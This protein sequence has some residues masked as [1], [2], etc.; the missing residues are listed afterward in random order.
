MKLQYTKYF[1]VGPLGSNLFLNQRACLN[2][3]TGSLVKK[4]LR[5]NYFFLFSP[6]LK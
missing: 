1:L 3:K 4:T 6:L 2:F 5:I